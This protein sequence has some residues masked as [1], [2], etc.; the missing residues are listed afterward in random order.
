MIAAMQLENAATQLASVVRSL[1]ELSE[2]HGAFSRGLST[3]TSQRSSQ[4]Q[5]PAGDRWTADARTLLAT[6]E[7]VPPSL[8][9]AAA[10][11]RV[12]ATTA[13]SL[14]AD[15]ARHESSLAAAEATA[16]SL[17]RRRAATDPQD[18]D[19]LRS[20]AF[21]AEDA[22]ATQRIAQRGIERC[23]EQWT[24]ACRSA[25]TVV[26]HAV[27]VLR[28]VA[29][30]PALVVDRSPDAARGGSPFREAIDAGAALIGSS[31][32]RG[33][34]HGY[35]TWLFTQ[36]AGAVRTMARAWVVR[37]YL[38]ATEELRA[39]AAGVRS[40]AT[41][42]WRRIGPSMAASRSATA[43]RVASQTERI[44]S[45]ADVFKHGRG[46]VRTVGRV[47]APVAAV[48]DASTLFGGSQYDGTRGTT[49]R[50]MAGV[51]LASTAALV[52]SGTAIAA[53]TVLASP[54]IITAAVVGATAATIWGVGNLV[55]DNRERIGHA[56]SGAQSAVASV[57]SSVA[58]GAT[59]AVGSIGAGISG[60]VRSVGR[61]FGFGG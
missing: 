39:V 50:A 27:A 2:K 51:G 56:F 21:Q 33:A 60:G 23:A 3:V 47:A 55:Y 15:V 14:A 24:A 17:S 19:R 58:S 59:T 7:Q 26:Q 13:A 8:H 9:G 40:F 11:V 1:E 16:R 38:R 52:V 53:G 41:L 30:T 48:G 5:S 22:I 46:V 28:A 37:E 32:V 54:V 57:T 31:A 49:D 29:A 10:A 20:L 4:W 44:T 42:Q 6:A 34:L 36:R 12:L 35:G 43:T 18:A 25:H 45:A 61:V